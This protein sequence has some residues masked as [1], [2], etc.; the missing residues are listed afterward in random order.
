MKSCESVSFSER[1]SSGER[2]SGNRGES[3]LHRAR[4]EESLNLIVVAI[5]I[6]LQ[7]GFSGSGLKVTDK[8]MRPASPAFDLV[9]LH[10]NRLENR[11]PPNPT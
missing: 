2:V 5:C 3:A 10:L 4:H 8:R 1:A 9:R 7:P 11:N 6:T